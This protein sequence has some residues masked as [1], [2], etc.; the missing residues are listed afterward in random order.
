MRKVTFLTL[1]LAIP[2]SWLRG[3]LQH[4]HSAA[5]RRRGARANSQGYRCPAVAIVPFRPCGPTPSR[6]RGILLRFGRGGMRQH[7]SSQILRW[8]SGWHL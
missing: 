4:C 2:R 1:E 6:R 8:R 3:F 5:T 7:R